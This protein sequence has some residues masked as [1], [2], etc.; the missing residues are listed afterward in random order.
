MF[1]HILVPLD[2]SALAECALP[3]AL[4]TAR[5]FNA[6]ITLFH[7][8]EKDAPQEI[9]G[10]RHLVN[11]GEALPYL[12]KLARTMPA[13]IVV[14]WHVHSELTENVA[15][16][17]VAHSAELDHDLI[18]MCSHGHGAV[19]DFLVGSIANKVIAHGAIPLMLVRPDSTAGGDFLGFST[20]LA[21]LDNASV[22]D[23]ALAAAALFAKK[24]GKEL[25]LLSVVP[26]VST[27]RGQGGA[28][29]R[30]LPGAANALLEMEKEEIR[31]H[32]KEHLAELCRDKVEARILVD[33]G[34]PARR[35]AKE[36]KRS[37]NCL[38]VLGTHGKAGMGAFWAGSVTSKVVAITK[39][40]ILLIPIGK[41]DPGS[42]GA[43]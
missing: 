37:G 7:V 34:D 42:T 31:E 8:A 25:V 39:T 17:I 19:K 23:E 20:I 2:G 21:P 29:G 11:G 38:L 40:V 12:E 9:H 18:V 13:D 33:R 4:Y 14:D 6:K 3:I 36:A 35:I 32:L 43:D 5:I 28:A 24:A 10:Q 41:P 15:K 16:N 26:T 1:S 22:H 30:L 27:L